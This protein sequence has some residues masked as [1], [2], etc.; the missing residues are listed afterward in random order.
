[1][2]EIEE[3]GLQEAPENGQGEDAAEE[4][5]N[6]GGFSTPEEL[7]AAYQKTLADKE[8]LERLKGRMGNELGQIRSEHAKLTGMVEALRSVREE[9][10]RQGVST[11]SVY[12]QLED[13]DI[14]EAQALK[15]MEKALEDRYS[16]EIKRVNDEFAKF[17]ESYESEKY[18]K[19]FLSKPENAGYKD[20]FERG[21]LDRWLNQGVPGEV[22]WVHYKAEKAEA[23]AKELEAKIATAKTE[24]ERTGLQRGAQLERGKTLAAKVLGEGPGGRIAE[25]PNYPGKSGRVRAGVQYLENLRRKTI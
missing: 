2:A 6:Y 19:D 4:A 13:G 3:N 14:N 16:R 7:A 21:D 8:N 23:K 15:M 17:R 24:A 18:V 20:A 9:S 22:A 10:S 5:P 25:K 11:E 1:M 12:Q